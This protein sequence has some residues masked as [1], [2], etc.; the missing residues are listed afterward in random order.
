MEKLGNK[1]TKAN[2]SLSNNTQTIRKS[3]NIF[4]D[5]K[6]KLNLNK[7]NQSKAGSSLIEP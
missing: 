1:K 6:I 7:K 5:G 2:H 3:A 4:K